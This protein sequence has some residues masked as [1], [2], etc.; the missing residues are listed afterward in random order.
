MRAYYQL[1]QKINDV[2]GEQNVKH[3]ASLSVNNNQI[4]KNNDSRRRT[5][6]YNSDKSRV[7]E[8]LEPPLSKNY[9]HDPDGIK[10][11]PKKAMPLT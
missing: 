9:Y 6:F 5:V 11:I 10:M 4:R 7:Q 2:T 3:R 1:Y 8:I